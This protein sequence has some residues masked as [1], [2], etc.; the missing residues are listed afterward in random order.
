MF[1]GKGVVA[2]PAPSSWPPSWSAAIN[3][4]RSVAGRLLQCGGEER[5]LRHRANVAV[6]EEGDTRPVR[7][8]VRQPSWNLDTFEGG[9]ERPLGAHV[10]P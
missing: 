3:N 8:H 2:G 1:P 9:H 10:S 5:R 6:A 7:E 4:G